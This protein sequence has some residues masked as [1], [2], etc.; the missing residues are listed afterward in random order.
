[1]TRPYLLQ[2]VLMPSKWKVSQ[3][4]KKTKRLALGKVAQYLWDA[5]TLFYKVD[6]N[7][8]EINQHDETCTIYFIAYNCNFFP[9]DVNSTACTVGY[10]IPYHTELLHKK[11]KVG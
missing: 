3:E 2:L 11:Y 4:H 1:M 8:A 10:A 6:T 5:G 9:D 7:S